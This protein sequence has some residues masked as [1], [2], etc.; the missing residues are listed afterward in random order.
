MP[1]ARARRKHI[2]PPCTLR[3]SKMVHAIDSSNSIIHGYSIRGAALAGGAGGIRT[4]ARF[5]PPN[6]LAGGPL[7][8]LGYRSKYIKL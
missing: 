3:F 1:G 4:L 7:E 5:Y 2:L 8:P 6:P